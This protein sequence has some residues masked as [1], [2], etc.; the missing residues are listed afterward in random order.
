[1]TEVF[2]T[3]IPI[4]K[5]EDS[6]IWQCTYCRKNFRDS[7]DAK[8]HVLFDHT[9]IGFHKCD[10]GYTTLVCDECGRYSSYEHIREHM[11]F[12]RMFKTHFGYDQK[13]YS[14]TCRRCSEKLVKWEM[15][16]ERL[17]M[18]YYG[19]QHMRKHITNECKCLLFIGLCS[20]YGLDSDSSRTIIQYV[21]Q[22]NAPID[23][24]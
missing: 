7:R 17:D 21:M 3:L 13:I 14:I 5:I 16:D 10:C 4:V 12:H 22:M 18:C 1:M 23:K 11:E 2:H 20:K 6:G 15:P 9:P 24:K 19:M 8:H